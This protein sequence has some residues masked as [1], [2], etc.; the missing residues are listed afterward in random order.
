M[1]RAVATL[2][3]FLVLVACGGGGE[4]GGTDSPLG[5]TCAEYLSGDYVPAV[6]GDE[7]EQQR[8]EL[9][10]CQADAP[11]A[12]TSETSPV[13]GNAPT[14]TLWSNFA[15][16]RA[17]RALSLL[18]LGQPILAH[19]IEG[20]E[21]HAW[22]VAAC[23]ELKDNPGWSL[24]D[25]V[26]EV[27]DRPLFSYATVEDGE[28]V[29]EQGALVWDAGFNLVVLLDSECP[30]ILGDRVRCELDRDLVRHSYILEATHPDS[31]FSQAYSA[32]LT[33]PG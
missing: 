31:P 27:T 10:Q 14:T 29:V 8:R 11:G 25:Y 30:Q 17:R 4:D 20:E 7:L 18:K 33:G 22:A 23:G 5:V 24:A 3:G 19:D 21:V 6:G 26:A 16:T 2:A 13:T 1:R 28:V 9:Q 12:A 15:L 32:C